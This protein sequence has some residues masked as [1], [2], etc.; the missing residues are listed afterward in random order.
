MNFWTRFF[1]SD[2]TL[3][4]SLL[5]DN[6]GTVTSAEFGI[7]IILITPT[8]YAFSAILVFV[9]T[10]NKG[11]LSGTVQLVSRTIFV[12]FVLQLDPSS[13][14]I[15]CAIRSATGIRWKRQAK[16]FWW[17]NWNIRMVTPS[18]GV[19][20]GWIYINHSRRRRKI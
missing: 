8:A 4:F 19:T 14:L 16:V 5:P 7:S 6:S 11:P 15:S 10:L 13:F 17:N 1:S 2:W 18:V 12:N 20:Q 3:S 9:R